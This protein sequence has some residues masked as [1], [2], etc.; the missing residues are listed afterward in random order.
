MGEIDANVDF[1]SGHAPFC[2][3]YGFTSSK[4]PDTPF[5]EQGITFWCRLIVTVFK[6][7]PLF[8][9]NFKYCLNQYVF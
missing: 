4:D 3:H 2:D 8:S 7:A 9:Q 1:R 6:S 5:T